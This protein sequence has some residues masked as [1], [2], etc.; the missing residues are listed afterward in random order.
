MGGLTSRPRP[1]RGAVRRADA[2]RRRAYHRGRRAELLCALWLRLKGYRI[3]A[4]RFRSAAGEIDIVARRGPVLAFVEVKARPTAA[5][6]QWAIGPRQQR[7]LTRAA[8]A[9]L[10]A[11]P[12]LAAVT[13]GGFVRFD[14]MIA[15]PWRWPRHVVNAW[16]SSASSSRPGPWP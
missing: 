1:R 11:R 8:E 4:R 16:W 13:A 3:L 10:A 6:G 12:D 5:A 7:R 2:G 15:T 14:V 9:F